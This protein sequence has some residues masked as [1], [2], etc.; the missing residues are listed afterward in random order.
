M[1]Q[2]APSTMARRIVIIGTFSLIGRCR[3]HHFLVW[4]RQ[5]RCRPVM[6]PG[7]ACAKPEG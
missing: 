3:P 2:A 4:R 7:K 5:G 6:G 1:K